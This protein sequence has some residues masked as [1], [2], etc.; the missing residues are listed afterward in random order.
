MT[1]ELPTAVN[2]ANLTKLSVDNT[3]EVDATYGNWSSYNGF[4]LVNVLSKVDWINAG[5]PY[6]M[7]VQLLNVIGSGGVDL[8]HPGVMYNVIDEDNFDTAFFR[9][10][11]CAEV[12]E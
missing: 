12:C 3:Y 9:F 2:C 11:Y 10:V 1:A 6:T 7:T 8:G 4:C 5:D